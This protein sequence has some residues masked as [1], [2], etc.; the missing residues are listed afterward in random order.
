MEQRIQAITQADD[1]EDWQKA[2]RSGRRIR[3]KSPGIYTAFDNVRCAAEASSAAEQ[4]GDVRR[5]GPKA[6]SCRNKLLNALALVY[7]NAESVEHHFGYTSS[8]YRST[9]QPM[10]HT[11]TLDESAT[12]K[13]L[14]DWSAVLML[15]TAE[16]ALAH[17]AAVERPGPT[18][19]QLAA[20]AHGE[21]RTTILL[22]VGALSEEPA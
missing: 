4:A 3:D 2:L 20:Q 17:R 6:R 5:G 15:R 1:N 7:L 21:V 11:L 14:M 16:A 13:G 22:W 12:Q 18:G 8:Q 9:H 19:L 10:P